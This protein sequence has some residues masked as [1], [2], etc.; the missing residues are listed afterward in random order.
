VMVTRMRLCHRA[1]QAY[2][3]ITAVA[4]AARTVRRHLHCR[5]CGS[6][7]KVTF[8]PFPAAH[9]TRGV[10]GRRPPPSGEVFLLLAL[11]ELEMFR[12]AAGGGS[13]ALPLT[14]MDYDVQ[15]LAASVHFKSER[16]CGPHTR[17]LS[18][19]FQTS[20]NSAARLPS[21]CSTAM[22]STCSG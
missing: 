18:A 15:R 13:F 19:R 17:R 14:H 8:D 4:Y 2:H 21:A 11:I 22:D 7:R 16:V 12:A 1:C 5:C 6:W 3:H 9:R 10:V 20:L